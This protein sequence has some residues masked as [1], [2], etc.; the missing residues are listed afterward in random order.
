[1]TKY[2][3]SYITIRTLLRSTYDTNIP[4]LQVIKETSMRWLVVLL[5]IAYED[6]VQQKMNNLN[7]SLII[8]GFD[9]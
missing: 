2:S 3:A 1:M 6:I 4:H 8:P 5:I 9:F 7:K